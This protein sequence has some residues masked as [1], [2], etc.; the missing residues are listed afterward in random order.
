[1]GSAK[2]AYDEPTRVQAVDGEVTLDG[3]DGVG[4]SMTPNAAELTGRRLIEA[5][6]EARAQERPSDS[7]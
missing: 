3:P 4:L 1:M 2:E 6:Q 7:D 5:A